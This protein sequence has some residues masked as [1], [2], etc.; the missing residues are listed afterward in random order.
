MS[1]VRTQFVC[2]QCGTTS[3]KWL[4]RC[5]DC[6]EW[7]C[8]IEEKIS[9]HRTQAKSLLSGGAEVGP[10]LL[11]EMG[12][13]DETRHS[14]TGIGEFDRVLGGGF[15]S[16]SAVLIGGDPG[17][18][19]S[20][21]V[22][23]AL[24]CFSGGNA[25]LLYI[26]GE[27]SAS[28]IKMRA[29][30][31]GIDSEALFI[32]T[33]NSMELILEQIE[34]I[35]PVVVAIDSVQTLY[36]R[37]IESSPGTISQVREGA[38]K[39]IQTAKATGMA[40]IL[41]GHV[42]KEGAI[43]GP[44]VLEHMVDT[45]LYFEGEKGHPFRLLRAVKNRF[46]ATSEIGVFEMTGKGLCE[47]L[48]P[49]ELFLA[50]RLHGVAGSA[51]V[52]SLEGSRPLLVELQALV[53]S[54]GLA[55]PRRTAIGIDAGRVAL[56]IAVLEKIVGL[57]LHDKD[58]FLNIAG[59]LRVVEPAVDLGAVVAIHS[60]LHNVAIDP[61]IVLIGEVGLSGEVRAVN[62]CEMRIK[63]IQKMGFK[64]CVV[65]KSNLKN[66]GADGLEV[67]GVSSVDEC[68]RMLF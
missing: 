24:G 51:V 65:P 1:K 59:G 12:S 44:K 42:T 31:L 55:N 15:V 27:E 21:I 53:S 20:T 29:D 22:M 49:S 26:S 13:T 7:N 61:S 52:T 32:Y 16:G 35:R 18:G 60:S 33:E 4:G 11:S 6:G 41:I 63:E 2:Q 39:L 56:L 46:G 47:V 50:E 45:V 64:K 19:K 10:Q 36:S 14:P 40:L 9:N 62:G 37:E 48:N 23:Q 25:K 38:Y 5:P 57:T 67:I 17:I 54:S 8:Y 28:Q 30:R 66:A 43:A 58:I 68:L 34:K 3:P